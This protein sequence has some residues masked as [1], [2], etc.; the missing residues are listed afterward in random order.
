MAA[1]SGFTAQKTCMEH[2]LHPK[3]NEEGKPVSY[4]AI[5]KKILKTEQMSEEASRAVLEPF[6]QSNPN[7]I[8]DEK[9][10]WKTVEP[11]T[12]S[13]FLPDVTFSVVDIETTGGRPPQHR[14]TE[15]AAVKVKDGKVIDEYHMLVNPGREIPWSV[16][17][18]TGITDAMVADQP[19]LIDVLPAFLEF[20]DNTVFVA[21]C[22]NFD[23]HFIRYF[24]SEY[25]D[26]EI[27]P[28]VL[29][30][31]KLA[32]RL[33]PKAGRYNLGELSSFL[34]IPDD[35]ND[36]HRALGDSKTTAQ[37]LICFLRMLQT[38]GLESL[39]GVIDYQDAPAK[40]LPPLADGI[41]IDPATLDDLPT[42]R[43]V[44]RLLN[45]KSETVYS[46]KA[47]DIQKAV[48]D[49]FYPKNRSASKF[50]QK[51]RIVR[52]IDAHP[53]ESE[54]GISLQ[55]ARLRRESIGMNGAMP[56]GGAGFLKLS[57]NSKYPRGYAV[58]HL[59]MD[60]SAYY[61]P[62]R[63]Q[64]QLRDLLG[65][66]HSVF[67]LRRVVRTG[68]DSSPQESVPTPKG[69][70]KK[71]SPPQGSVPPPKS[72]KKKGSPSREARAESPANPDIPEELY[73]QLIERLQR[74]LEGRMRRTSEGSLLALLEQAW[75]K[76]GPSPAQLSRNL[77]RLRHLV[78][79]H[80]L[81]SPSVERRNLLIVE[82]GENM[83][84]RVC[85]FVR[86]G[87]L[88]DEM[89]FE[90]NS[91]PVDEL[92]ARIQAVFFGEE[93]THTNPSKDAL[94]EAAIIAAWLRR[95]LMDGFAMNISPG[96]DIEEVLQSLLRALGDPRAAGTKISI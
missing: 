22:A 50:A 30:T 41:L 39:Q 33:L 54:L 91:P 59:T 90:K 19:D 13:R 93:T 73:G 29:C 31:F 77:K 83:S 82:P 17:R 80:S 16:V 44:F 40:E 70:K 55:A 78:Q 35:E 87:L 56:A 65:A 95:E 75:G 71:G 47:P 8:Q 62:F 26:R 10:R 21:H 53:L 66:I 18:L 12:R 81:S 92:G 94:E 52:K 49:L 68:K 20:I 24:A 15:L 43:G 89:E 64:A 37:I 60:G 63:K 74:M 88:V 25:L 96:K 42:E 69:S 27:S 6:L 85:Y 7:F 28:E 32:Q 84:R 48:R 61:G 79:T 72:S 51:L 2:L 36:R 1:R 38:L 58:N 23:F 3:L 57:L 5:A 4:S 86:G 45:A 14:V 76:K 46:G 11:M 67:P 9:G 34:S